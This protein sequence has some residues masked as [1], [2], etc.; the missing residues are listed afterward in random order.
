MKSLLH[1]DLSNLPSIDSL[2]NTIDTLNSIN[3]KDISYS[4]LWLY[5]E[6]R[7]GSIPIAVAKLNQDHFIERGRLHKSAE[8]YYRCEKDISYREDIHNIKEYGRANIPFQSM[9]YGG[10]KSPDIAYSRITVLTETSNE[11]RN[12]LKSKNPSIYSTLGKWRISKDFDV[13]DIIFNKSQINE[14][15]DIHQSYFDRLNELHNKHPQEAERIEMI[16]NFFTMHFLKSNINSHHDYK[17]SAIYT[18]M[19]LAKNPN[20]YGVC[21]PGIR[22]SYLGQCVAL[23][24]F[25][26]NSFC[27][28]EKATVVKVTRP[29][30]NYRVS[31]IKVATELGPLCTD[32]QW[33]DSDK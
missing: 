26:I 13:L 10:L 25:A 4:K 18:Q 33:I 7:F 19:A 9:F 5:I 1:A 21:Y 2:K 8:D 30:E 17:I 31:T 32:F 6:K 27:R 20:I 23:T 24:P 3:L 29:E 12:Q 22:S 15:V 28:L 11:F 14:R 16:L